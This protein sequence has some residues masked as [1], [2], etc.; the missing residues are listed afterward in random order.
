[1]SDKNTIKSVFAYS[2]LG[3]QLAFFM[4]LFVYGGYKLDN[5]MKTSPLFTA[6]GA[7]LGFGSGLYNLLKGL[8]QMDKD[9]KDEKSNSNKENKSKWL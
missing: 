1:L 5:H 3:I 8:R 7:L 4:V 9:T 6:L 2:T